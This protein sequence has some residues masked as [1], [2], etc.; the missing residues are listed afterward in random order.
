[1]AF[2]KQFTSVKKIVT[3]G[4]HSKLFPKDFRYRIGDNIYTVMKEFNDGDIYFRRVIGSDGSVDDMT[5]ESIIRDIE[6][7]PNDIQVEIE[8]VTEP[9]KDGNT[10]KE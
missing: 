9:E 1:M 8:I 2:K 3:S 4:D 7:Q 6:E 10:E 5:V